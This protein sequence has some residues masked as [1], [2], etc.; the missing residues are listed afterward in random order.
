MMQAKKTI[1]QILF[2][3]SAIVPAFVFGQFKLF[4]PDTREAQYLNGPGK[5]WSRYQ[6]EQYF[7]WRN[8]ILDKQLQQADDS[9]ILRRQKAILNGNKITAEIWNFGSI[10]S[11]GNTTTD[12]RWEGLG[13]GYE[14][15]PFICAEVEVDPHKHIDDYFKRDDNGDVITNAQGDTIWY[16]RVISD[17]LVSLG[18]EISPD[19]KEFWGW[20]PLA[21]ND[22][23]VPYADPNVDYIPTSNDIDRDGDGKPDSWPEGWYN[24]NL[25]EYVW[26]GALRQGA[27]NSDMESFFVVDDRLNREFNYFPYPT[28]STRR[29]LGVE[30]E[31]RYY[32]WSN[33]LAEDI[34]FLIY[35]VSN[36]SPKDL[37]NV[38]FG[39]WGDP[40]IGGWN[41]WQD[42]LSFFDR[43]IN[44]VYCWDADRI[45]DVAGKA[46]GYFGYKFLESPGNPYDGIDNDNDGM[47]DESQRDG[48][49]NDHD[50]NPDKDDIG[51]DGL[52]NT[53]DTGEGDGLPTAGDPYDIRQPGEPNFEWT[54]LDESDMIGLTGF[55]S[56]PFGGNNTISNDQYVYQNFLQPGFFDSA[57]ANTPGDYIFIYSSGPINLP[58]GESRRFSIAL[59]VGENHDDLTLNALTAQDIYEKNYQFA[60]PPDKPH[61][62]AVPGDQKVTLYWDDVAESSI[63]P[64][65]RE[66]DF[67]GY[68]IYRSTDPQFLDQQTI[69]DAHGS[70][71]LFQPLESSNGAKAKF[72]LV[73]DYYGL[74]D[75]EYTGRGVF[76][77]LGANTGIVHSYVDS[78][79]VING[80]TYYY[81][82]ASYDHGDDSLKI[83]PVECSKLITVN[84][85]NNEVFLDVNT[86]Q[87]IPRAP[88]AG[89]QP[90]VV[91]GDNIFHLTGNSTGSIDL[92][93]LD[94]MAVEDLDTFKITFKE[95]PTRFSVEDR[96]AIE[97]SFAVNSDKYVSLLYKHI[98][99]STF[100]VTSLDGDT[101]YSQTTDYTLDDV[102][103]KIQ[104]ILP[105]SGGRM[106]DGQTYVAN[107]TYFPVFE[108][109]LVNG[110]ESN[111]IFNGLNIFVHDR[112]LEI[113]TA[114]TGWNVTSP[115]NYRASIGVYHGAPADGYKY[116]GDFEFRWSNTIADTGNFGVT[117]PFE[118]Y[119]V[120][121]GM[122]PIQ[123]RFAIIEV[124]SNGT[125][126]PGDKIIL[127]E[128][129]SGVNPTWQV[130]FTVPNGMNEVKP[131][132]GD[133]F[134]IITNRPFASTDSYQF[135][136]QASHEDPHSAK[137]EMKN[138][139]VVPNPYVVTNVIE[140]LDL[141]N[142]RDRGP[143]RVYF[144]HLPK[145]CTIHIYNI[146]GELI[147]TLEH[148][149]ALDDG[150]EFWNLT[151][152]DNFPI[153]YG[154][155]IFH[156]D[157][158][159][160]GQKIGR[161]AVIK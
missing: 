60:K 74:S 148:H 93:T 3:T 107:Y 133:V 84:P 138:I 128:G 90:G 16:A 139:A 39:M 11:P 33:P 94:P 115:T 25:K 21:Y 117:V 7:D 78:N 37:T 152:H 53:G 158:G 134:T 142:T 141:Q 92:K 6:I 79:N 103:G 72:D 154:I 83:A 110:E 20:Q 157:A 124:T 49:D 89:Y 73:N 47:I 88:V 132:D 137:A 156:V 118:I 77:N 29:G 143:R 58:A 48:I 22:Q 106:A 95:D 50:W 1:I 98:N 10:S 131:V 114:A 69:T 102:N 28:D 18:G 43:D 147:Q 86:T 112:D 23:G 61:V 99:D 35:K 31:C 161:F 96:L 17:G 146:S 15:G 109:E 116:P 113:N 123:W 122:V 44:M 151:T 27:S 91:I 55:A 136:T 144:N 66:M 155:Y 104:P 101:V 62:T 125:W 12:I 32:Q 111:P 51:I 145:D 13:Y 46:P 81:A 70:K 135:V 150:K 130:V 160:I 41:N 149:S 127:L 42:D 30:T 119:E 153:S 71:F 26:P 59:I 24:P 34:I 129:D 140:P 80:Q 67:E 82:V 57:N 68:V 5:D 14:F 38:T 108:S 97:D 45:S 9:Q 121:N 36:K 40:H 2:I 4:R 75:I 63:D 100:S 87:I 64:I 126:D 85:E 19:G 76:Y 54:D 52:Q 105:D 159:D 120:T 65:S 56:P 8:T